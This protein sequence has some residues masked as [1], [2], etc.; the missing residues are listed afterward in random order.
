MSRFN[1]VFLTGGTGFFGAHL[2]AELLR[3]GVQEIICHV[4]GGGAE[5][6]LGALQTYGLWDEAWRGKITAIAGD[7]EEPQLGL[8]NQFAALPSRIDAVVHNGAN[9]N[10]VFGLKQLRAA[11]VTATQDAL[12]IA[13]AASVPFYFISTLRMFDHRLD[14]TPIKESDAIDMQQAVQIGYGHSKVLSER[15]VTAASMRGL[16]TA[17][18][19]PG[20]MCGDG[21]IGAPNQRD[22]ISLML[23]GC[24][25]LGAA[26]VSPLQI[27]LTSV[28][29]AARGMVALTHRTGETG[30][31]WHLVRDQATHM[32]AFF[33]A[34]SRAGYRI[35]MI[36]Y[37]GWVDRLR[38]AAGTGQNTLAPLLEY[39]TPDFPEQTTR[40]VFDSSKTTNALAQLGVTHPDIDAAFLDANISGMIACGFFPPL[41]H[42]A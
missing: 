25:M 15:L 40:R 31:I 9:V 10:Y 14:G 2:I 7:L 5:R 27:N 18:F 32:E 30:E 1:T 37:E 33:Q 16:E 35:D 24:R 12:R 8:G 3:D 6:I 4:R 38:D 13:E 34:V 26:P 11:N 29:Y 36:P 23:N 20:L 17:I 22:A 39:F 28:N 41:E 19:R 21:K 42:A